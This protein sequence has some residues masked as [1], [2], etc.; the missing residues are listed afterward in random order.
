MTRSG[1]MLREKIMAGE[2]ISPEEALSLFSWGIIDLGLMADH[3][4]KLAFPD[5]QVGFIIDRI[6]NFTN[7]CEAACRFCAFHARAGRIE[8][9]ELTKEE[10]ISKVDALIKIGGTQ[11]M[12]QGGLHPKRSLSYY[13]D[14]A[15]TIK[16]AFPM[17]Y[18]HSFSPAEIIHASRI[19]S[20]TIDKAVSILKD[21]GVDSVPGASDLL[22]D[23]IRAT[24]SPRKC[25]VD[26]WRQVMYALHR[27][28]I[29]SSATMTF[30][31]GETLEERV[32]HLRV[33]RDVQDK[34][35]ILRAFIPW[36]FSPA[37]TEMK[38]VI[39]ASGVDY[40]KIVTIGR[41][42]LDNITYIQAGWLTEGLK[43]AQIALAMGANDM[44]GVLMEETVVKATGVVTTTNS[45]QLIDIIRNAG[46]TPVQRDSKYQIVRTFDDGP[47]NHA[48][49]KR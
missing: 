23:R 1:N 40:L 7:I 6:I 15:R 38:D 32:E 19:D 4:R 33:V 36:S 49:I 41:I 47:T 25:T 31:M 17:V 45:A 2:R 44:G 24:A 18:L 8:P 28:G 20:V 27:H 12:L 26:E 5:E 34:T 21:A 39:P 43:L 3:R 42:F 29:K 11:V 46:K 30:G 9:Y 14:L 22:V 48:N 35:G 13:V 10:I 16:S 37:L